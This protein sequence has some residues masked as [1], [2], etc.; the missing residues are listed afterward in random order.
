MFKLPILIALPS[1]CRNTSIS[2][3]DSYEAWKVED[4]GAAS[5]YEKLDFSREKLSLM[6]REFKEKRTFV[7]EGF[8][9]SDLV[10]YAKAAF[11]VFVF[12][13]RTA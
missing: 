9:H 13:M 1:N 4:T 8:W 6:R 11:L 12:S 3:A 10:K 2:P 7:N 5:S